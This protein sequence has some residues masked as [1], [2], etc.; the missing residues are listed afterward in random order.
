MDTEIQF[1]NI[2]QGMS[3]VQCFLDSLYNVTTQILELFLIHA[4]NSISAIHDTNIQ[5]TIYA[6]L[7]I[8]NN[9]A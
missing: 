8:H 4:K 6:I 9:K 3:T 2:M 7:A 5:Y 1:N